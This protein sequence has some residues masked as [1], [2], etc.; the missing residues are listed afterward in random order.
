M[1]TR[2]G[3]PAGED[4]TVVLTSALSPKPRDA[5]RTDPHHIYLQL[6]GTNTWFVMTDPDNLARFKPN[7]SP[8]GEATPRATCRQRDD[9]AEV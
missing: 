5:I 2:I 9:I 7:G 3:K 8:S 4:G 1:F 6:D